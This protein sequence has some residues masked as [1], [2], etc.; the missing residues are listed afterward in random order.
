MLTALQKS[1]YPKL[2]TPAKIVWELIHTGVI[3]ASIEMFDMYTSYEKG[4]PCVGTM[5]GDE[6]SKG[7]ELRLGPSPPNWL[8]NLVVIYLYV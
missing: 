8:L 3:N 6:E 2:I 5:Q 7:K 4:I 1:L